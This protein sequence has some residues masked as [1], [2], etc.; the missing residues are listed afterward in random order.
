MKNWPL[1]IFSLMIAIIL[2][3]FVNSEGNNSVISF[4]VPV[5]VK[6]IPADK[7]VV[8]ANSRQVQVSLRGPSYLVSRYA[9][10]PSTFKIQ[11]PSNVN[12]SYLASLNR[13]DLNLPRE[14]QLVSV[15]PAEIELK[16]DDLIERQ[17]PVV[18]PKIGNVADG[19]KLELLIVEPDQAVLSG[20][21]NDLLKIKSIE[22]EALDLQAANND[23]VRQLSLR[24][25][26]GALSVN[27]TEVAVKAKVAP[28]QLTK[29]FDGLALEVRT[30][31]TDKWKLNQATVDIEISGNK[32]VLAKIN[33]ANIIPY[34]RPDP[35]G[36]DKQA[37]KISV[38][39]PADVSLTLVHPS[40]AEI[41]RLPDKL[42]STTRH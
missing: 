40:V 41:K 21:K 15:D 13:A 14:I 22:T 9:A 12:E 37:L 5:E 10:A 11:I 32:V 18:V 34:V 23:F 30:T 20:P 38:D 26:A 31:T 39:L 8:W 33:A 4:L 2:M 3:L 19:S 36:A 35:Q 42:S 24:M 16:L 25:P 1:K 7:V 17:I 6:N 28:V 29:R 27:P